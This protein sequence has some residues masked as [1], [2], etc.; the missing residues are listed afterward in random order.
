MFQSLI[1]K[2]VMA[3][4]KKLLSLGGGALVT[5]GLITS[6]QSAQLLGSVMTILSIGW[7]AVQIWQSHKAVKAADTPPEDNI[8]KAV[9][10]AAKF[11]N[12][13]EV[14]SLPAIPGAKTE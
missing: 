9:L 13:V 10:Q 11:G 8:S 12:D 14:A 2:I 6:D 7:E 5:D 1:L 3:G 4:A